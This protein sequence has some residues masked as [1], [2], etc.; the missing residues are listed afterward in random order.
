MK[1]NIFI[2]FKIMLVSFVIVFG[3]LGSI[4]VFSHCCRTFI[5]LATYIKEFEE[6]DPPMTDD[7]KRM[8]T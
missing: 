4:Y 2:S 5:M 7:I 6:D 1:N 8:Y 3:V